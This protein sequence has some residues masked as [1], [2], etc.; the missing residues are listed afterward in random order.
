MKLRDTK[1]KALLLLP[2][3]ALA[4]TLA[5]CSSDSNDDADTAAAS[6][7]Q[8]DYPT[9][10]PTEAPADDAKA[11][12][13]LNGATGS[14]DVIGQTDDTAAQVT[15]QAPFSVTETTV[16]TLVE[17]DG[18]EVTEDSHVLVCYVGVNGRDGEIFDSAYQKGVPAD[19]PASGVVPGFKQ[20]LVGQHVGSVV[21]V[22]MTS[23]DGY[24]EGNPDAGIEV[25]DSLIFALKILAAV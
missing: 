5:G 13:E 18:A 6:T 10:C 23:E 7:S 22:A 1:L 11:Q 16:K 17:G 15:V 8:A 14:V 20:A 2:A 12:W 3:A 24:A 25:G 9:T 4:L 19:F 21:A